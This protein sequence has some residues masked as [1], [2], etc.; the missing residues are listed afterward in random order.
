[1]LGKAIRAGVEVTP[2]EGAAFLRDQP[3]TDPGTILDEE[4]VN[5]TI[6]GIMSVEDTDR[7]AT[8][9]EKYPTE[10]GGVYAGAVDVM[11]KS[12]IIQRYSEDWRERAKNQSWTGWGWDT[13]KQ[14]LGL[15]T[16]L[17]LTVNRGNMR[18]TTSWTTAGAM[19]EK[20]A[21]LYEM[22][23]DK[24]NQYL[25]KE[26]KAVGSHNTLDALQLIEGLVEY[27]ST[28]ATLDTINDLSLIPI[29][30][31]I[32]AGGKAVRATPKFFTKAGRDAA[33]E[34]T[35]FIGPKIPDGHD[36]HADFIGP[37]HPPGWK[38]TTAEKLDP[39]VKDGS[40]PKNG[41]DGASI[42]YEE[43]NGTKAIDVNSGY[44]KGV[45]EGPMRVNLANG[46]IADVRVTASGKIEGPH[47]SH[48]DP[49]AILAYEK[50][51]KWYKTGKGPDN[52][53]KPKDLID[54]A[55]HYQV[56]E[57]KRRKEMA[58]AGEDIPNPPSVR[59]EPTD[60]LLQD[61]SIIKINGDVIPSKAEVEKAAKE[62]FYSVF[63]APE[64]DFGKFFGPDPLQQAQLD[65]MAKLSNAR[66]LEPHE[67]L[68]VAGKDEAA[69]EAKVKKDIALDEA[70]KL[71]DEDQPF[72]A[73]T[74]PTPSANNPNV[75][76][77]NVQAPKGSEAILTAKQFLE[78]HYG[79]VPESVRREIREL[80]KDA[81]SLFAP[82]PGV[83]RAHFYAS[84]T[85]REIKN[86]IE[87]QDLLRKML[88]GQG[89]SRLD[90]APIDRAIEIAKNA[91]VR[92]NNNTE[93]MILDMRQILPGDSA[94]G[95]GYVIADIG[96]GA[97]KRFDN[98][99]DVQKFIQ[100]RGI[101][102]EAY[103]GIK[104]T[105]GGYVL[106]IHVPLDEYG[107]A[108][109]NVTPATK[110]R[111]STWTRLR[112]LMGTKQQFSELS[113]AQRTKAVLGDQRMSM[114]FERVYKPWDKLDKDSKQA[115]DN[116]IH[117]TM[118]TEA[119]RG[120]P[121]TR[122]WFF[123]DSFH[124]DDVAKQVLGRV[125]TSAEKE[126]YWAFK[127]GHEMDY[128]FRLT[129]RYRLKTVQ[130][131]KKFT[132][133]RKGKMMRDVFSEIEGREVKLDAFPNASGHN[134]DYTIVHSGGMIDQMN[135]KTKHD[136]A[137]VERLV[138][139]EGY[140][141]IQVWNPRDGNVTRYGGLVDQPEVTPAFIITPN[142]KRVDPLSMKGQ[143]GYAPGGHV[144]Y[145]SRIFLRQAKLEKG[146][147]A[148]DRTIFGFENEVEAAKLGSWMEKARVALLNKDA[149]A[150]DEA[151]THLPFNKNKLVNLF[152]PNLG[153]LD[154][155]TPFVITKQGQNSKKYGGKLL[156][157]ESWADH[158]AKRGIDT[159]T[160]LDDLYNPSAQLGDPF[161]NGRDP[162]LFGIKGGTED[163]PMI[164]LASA[165]LMSP[166]SVQQSA[167]R[168]LVK[169]EY[170]TDYQLASAVDYVNEFAD[171]LWYNGTRVTKDNL[172]RNPLFYLEHATVESENSIRKLQAQQIRNG[173][174]NLLGTKAPLD[175]QVE[176]MMDKV[177]S[178]GERTG[179][180]KVARYVSEKALPKIKDPLHYLQSAA[181]TTT[182]GL[183]NFAHLFIQGSAAFNPV[184]VS[185]RAGMSSIIP[186]IVSGWL[187]FTDDPN[188]IE[189]A[190]DLVGK[191]NP[192]WTKEMF[193]EAYNGLNKFEF[194]GVRQSSA[195]SVTTADMTLSRGKVQK[196]LDYG[197][198]FFETG[199]RVN[200]LACWNTA[201]AEYVWRNKGKVGKLNEY[202]WNEIVNKA[203]AYNIN[204]TKDANAVWQHR[205]YTKGGTQF[206]SYPAR[207]LE[208]YIGKD[209][210]PLEK[211]RLFAGQNMLFGSPIASGLL[212]FMQTGDAQGINTALNPFASDL[213]ANALA[214]GI[215]LEDTT[216]D[217]LNSGLASLGMEYM[218]GMKLDFVGRYGWNTP[219]FF[220][221][222][223]R[224]YNEIDN[225]V[226][227]TLVSFLGPSG[228]LGNHM[229]SSV[230]KVVGDIMDIAGGRNPEASSEL[231]V[232]DTMNALNRISSLSAAE[233]IWAAFNAVQVRT[234][235]GNLVRQAEDPYLEIL[236]L[237]L[238]TSFQQDKFDMALNA[239]NIDDEKVN[240]KLMK[241]IGQ[242]SDK[243]IDAHNRGD[244]DRAKELRE[245]IFNY[246]DSV[247]LSSEEIFKLM[248]PSL[249]RGEFRSDEIL[250]KA[251]KTRAKDLESKRALEDA[252]ESRKRKLENN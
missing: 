50:D 71:V 142:I 234:K 111:N 116:L 100:E 103:G 164:E 246:R 191:T 237:A 31:G 91:I 7:I 243:M 240:Q 36:L 220:E 4:Y 93:D 218:T 139:E 226:L 199:D 156:N 46:D 18:D 143:L 51:G 227:A 126:A 37:K 185:P 190:A 176:N 66:R 70:A 83:A 20:I 152:D 15:P 68:S 228:S 13:T 161:S 194:M 69:I 67:V 48:L 75:N 125:T 40:S 213:K 107:V 95:V 167:I 252:R 242:L 159:S 214:N 172:L 136:P 47:G 19:R 232:T 181:H 188:I 207:L 60:V 64:E 233:K 165:E 146:R 192:G 79:Q 59:P 11:V 129:Q 122:G 53:S 22:P 117:H 141:I 99:V 134:V 57:G 241:H 65:D 195:W 85:A 96:P 179:N 110:N 231:L 81:G 45:S 154:I 244:F 249:K 245:E 162:L 97:G 160:E 29:A 140:K 14:F 24:F 104:P 72:P 183:Y 55:E 5:K 200:R 177:M 248:Y 1:M 197:N 222:M 84:L 151:L 133:T 150:L 80:L 155:N 135:L 230:N 193:K 25:E 6:E 42:H 180:K 12:A 128:L 202:D 98:V 38:P 105:A 223:K 49:R 235:S 205:W 149:K 203:N 131:F 137:N 182:M 174:Q 251:G 114:L 30:T 173:I 39:P 94:T 247:T 9:L 112:H 35:Q 121:E 212:Y 52:L 217:A 147:Y 54:K 21:N 206:L 209:L 211:Y 196:F 239:Q 169:S 201:Y 88:E 3:R 225:T 86:M 171:E 119:E 118:V 82:E 204:M 144:K 130:G 170:F 27:S 108:H 8:M 101:P 115:I 28:K 10:G 106:E 163:A 132:L 184:F 153:G 77:P 43:V 157:G 224:N 73:A 145:K 74:A 90:K 63:E 17:N 221:Q 158:M 61:G 124:L 216:V 168:N 236:R 78:K 89:I 208:T 198:T 44:L 16:Y 229:I 186:N 219:Q 210:T 138:N 34:A 87:G 26:L 127:R 109:L 178:W 238:G 120:K 123:R 2:E 215:D 189:H 32:K 58:M 113:N 62:D 92:N 41:L 102:D 23:P 175:Q 250:K 56:T 33:R 187:R 76:V 166:M 148:G